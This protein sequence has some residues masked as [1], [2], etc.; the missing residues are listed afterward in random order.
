L[1]PDHHEDANADTTGEARVALVDRYESP[2]GD[3]V[4]LDGARGTF[5]CKRLA[6]KSSSAGR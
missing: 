2:S 6:K 4:V 5:V 3:E 1:L